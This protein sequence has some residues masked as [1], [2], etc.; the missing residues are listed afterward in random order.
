MARILILDD[1]E[2]IRSLLT[3]LLTNKNHEP[4]AAET[5]SEAVKY[6][7]DN[8]IDVVL[9]DIILPDRSGIDFLDHVKNRNPDIPVILMTGHPALETATTAVRSGAFDYL[10]KP[11]TTSQISSV[12]ASAVRLK[13]LSDENRLYKTKLEDLVSERTLSLEKTNEALQKEI[14]ERENA[15]KALEQSEIRYRNLVENSPDLIYDLDQNGCIISV[16]RAG[17]SFLKFDS[18]EKILGKPLIEFIHPDDRRI[19]E[20]MMRYMVEQKMKSPYANV[21]RF[22]RGD[23]SYVWVE[24]RAKL[25]FIDRESSFREFGIIR[26][27]TARKKTEEELMQYARDLELLYREGTGFSQLAPDDDIYTYIAEHFMAISGSAAVFV[28]SFDEKQNSLAVRAIAAEVED[29]EAVYKLIDGDPKDMSFEI[30]NSNAK[31]QLMSGK[32]VSVEGGLYETCFGKIPKETCMQVEELFECKEVYAKGFVWNKRLLATAVLISK[33]PIDRKDQRVVETWMH[34]AA[35]ALQRR[36]V[37]KAVRESEIMLS[38]QNL[39]LEQKNIALREL[40]EQVNEERA[41]MEEQI[42]ANVEKLLMPLVGR[43]KSMST[44][45]SLTVVN[46]IEEGLRDLTSKFGKDIS[47]KINK[48]SKRELEICNMVKNGLSSKEIARILAI[49]DRSVS[50]HRRNIRKKLGITNDKVNLASFLTQI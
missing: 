42:L 11:F 26:D 40:M 31:R 50:T 15:Q 3:R 2:T 37:E 45:M 17:A 28:S 13:E 25:I 12:V 18:I 24:R 20:R 38:K 22:L 48:L 21:F 29:T 32:L 10:S 30:T 1:E 46:L 49:S 9:A 6:F 4:Y 41:R 36:K 19:V 43:L 16:N 34:Q 33:L 27:I 23:D 47:S 7:D 35:T 8:E 14:V 39:I 5:V 44:Q